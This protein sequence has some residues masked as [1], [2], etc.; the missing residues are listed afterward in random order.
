MIKMSSV[1][2]NAPFTDRVV[3]HLL[4]E[5]LSFHL[6]TLA[7]FFHVSDLVVLRHTRL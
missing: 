1:G 2:C 5:S 4:V 3:N 6:D 7:Q